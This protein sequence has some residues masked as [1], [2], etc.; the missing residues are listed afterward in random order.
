M[1]TPG[2]AGRPPRALTF[3]ETMGLASS[4]QPGPLSHSRL[5]TVGFGGAETNVAIGLCRLDVHTTW[6]SRLGDDSLAD[7]IRRELRAEGVTVHAA[8]DSTAPTGFM[9]KERRTSTTAIVNY[10]RAGSAASRMTPQDVPDELIADADLVHVTGIT[11]ALS[12]A[13]HDTTLDVVGRAGAAGIPISFDLNYRSR[14]WDLDVARRTYQK[15]IPHCAVV[16]AGE[17][18]AAILPPGS[19]TGSRPAD[20][21]ARLI[22][23]GAD[24]VVIKRGPLGCT[25]LIDGQLWQQGALAVDVVD[26]VGAGDAFVAGYLAELLHGADP[27][28]R[29]RT[30]VHTGALACTVTGDWEGNPTRAD[31]DRSQSAE[32]VQ[33]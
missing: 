1:N 12:A 18:E 30:A 9:L 7:L 19:N 15:I 31:L 25:A 4:A 23:H 5:F 6:V 26:T 3:G 13:A 11:P 10:F 32:P 28:Q 21:A 24:S 27:G 14:L 20:L 17:D 8:T 22:D 16:F 33:R 29:L 2:D